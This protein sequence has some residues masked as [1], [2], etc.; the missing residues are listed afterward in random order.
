MSQVLHQSFQTFSQVHNTPDETG[1]LLATPLRQPGQSEQFFR[2]QVRTP[3]LFRETLI[4]L[5]DIVN[6]RFYRPDL[7]RLMDPVITCEPTRVRLECFSSCA[8][9][10]GRIDLDERFFN[11]YALHTRGSTNVDF[12]PA[13][14]KSV[15]LL[16]PEQRA[17]FEVGSEFIALNTESESA[18]EHK[19][20]LPERWLRG[21]LQSQALF[22]RARPWQSL[23]ALAARQFLLQVKTSEEREK[24]LIM[25]GKQLQPLSLAPSGSFQLP[26]LPVSGLHRLGL[27]RRLIPYLQGLDIYHT[28]EGGPSIWVAHLPHARATLA[29][30]SSIQRGFSGEGEAL[31]SLSVSQDSPNLAFLRSLV[32]RLDS[33]T[34]EDLGQLLALPEAE[35]AALTDTLATEGLLG[36]DT[37][38]ERYFYRVLPFVSAQRGRLDQAHNLLQAGQVELEQCTPLSGGFSARGWVRGSTA[39][40]QSELAVQAG[41]LSQGQCSCAWIQKHQLQRGPCKHLLALRFA[42]EALLEQKTP[43]ALESEAPHDSPMV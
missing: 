23:P 31:R 14:L 1:I 24:W 40:Y 7:W 25:R 26:I 42:A 43:I 6:S 41:Y 3:L 13:F 37:A 2:G 8:S 35:I 30:S 38:S 19:V 17:V 11:G 4:W 32:A 28:S 36:Y 29:L 15:S 12:N 27:F 34:L 22:R 10:Y 16:R 9:V 39:E 5:S 18:I 33:F 20:K 21:F